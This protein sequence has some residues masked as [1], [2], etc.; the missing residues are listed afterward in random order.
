[1]TDTSVMPA[2][3]VLGLSLGGFLDGIVLHQVLQWHHMLSTVPEEAIRTDITLNTLA[4]GLFHAGTW[5]L[6]VVGLLL[7]W[8][9]RRSFPATSARRFVGAMLTGAGS[10]NLIEGVIDHHLL[11][12][13]HVRPDSGNVLAWDVAFLALGLVLVVAGG[14]M[15]KKNG[16]A[17]TGDP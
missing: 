11:G 7:L 1:M 9:A 3:W 16:A 14:W 10:F 2:G 5:I 8:R 15:M 4:D 17:G 6:A 12:I 13:H